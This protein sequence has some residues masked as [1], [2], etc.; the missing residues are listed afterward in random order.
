MRASLV[1]LDSLTVAAYGGDLLQAADVTSLMKVIESWGTVLA[2]DHQAA[3]QQERRQYRPFGSTFKFNLAR[4]IVHLTRVDGGGLLLEQTKH[5][6]GPCLT[7]IGVALD[8]DGP[9]VRLRLVGLDDACLEGAGVHLPARERVAAALAAYSDGID[10][11]TLAAELGISVSTVR[12][13]LTALRKGKRA[14]SAGA[15]RW[16][17]V[18]RQQ[19]A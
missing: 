9:S 6:F 19:A 18:D 16:R 11:D 14:E 13:H 12:N 1:V 10:V 8:W 4:S 2:L 3:P 7:P 5:N 15:G 17:P